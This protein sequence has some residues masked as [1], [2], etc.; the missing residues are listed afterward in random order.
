[1]K[2]NTKTALRTA[3]M[4]AAHEARMKREHLRAAASKFATA[5]EESRRADAH[6]LLRVQDA[7]EGGAL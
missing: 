2:K 3:V 7:E 4:V 6:L 5:R 1:M